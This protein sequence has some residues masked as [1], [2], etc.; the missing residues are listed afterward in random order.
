M[1]VRCARLHRGFTLVELLTVVAVVAVLSTLAGPSMINLIATQRVRAV[2]GDL[3]LTLMKARGEAIKRN[4]SV[5]VARSGSNWHDGWQIN[6][7]EGGAVLSTVSVP[8]GVT[9]TNSP[10]VASVVYAANGRTSAVTSFVV[11]SSSGTAVR[12]VA[13]D[14]TGRPYVKDASSC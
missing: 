11:T 1:A 5:T 8:S 7:P 13:I 12:C 9:I 14:L 2:A 6:D 3:H 10:A 4:A